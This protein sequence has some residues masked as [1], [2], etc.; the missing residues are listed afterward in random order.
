MVFS[1]DQRHI[2]F[3]NTFFSYLVM[4][5]RELPEAIEKD[6]SYFDIADCFV[7]NCRKAERVL[8]WSAPTLVSRRLE[9]S[10]FGRVGGTTSRDDNCVFILLHTDLLSLGCLR[11]FA[12]R[13]ASHSVKH[14]FVHCRQINKR[15]CCGK[16]VDGDGWEGGGEG[17]ASH[18]R[19]WHWLFFSSQ[20]I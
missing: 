4:C 8:S 20:P 19:N 17:P 12:F 18:P 6:D 14:N 1:F 11:W 16:C 3:F 7:N 13:A 9:I 2:I 10:T 15:R 5:G